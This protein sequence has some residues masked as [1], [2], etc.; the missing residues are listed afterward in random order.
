[1]VA[2]SKPDEFHTLIGRAMND[3]AF[4]AKLIDPDQ[5]AQALRQVGI[6]NP[7][8]EQLTA[9]GEA[10]EAIERVSTAFGIVKAAM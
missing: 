8:R 4:R 2:T 6:E 9:I 1:M 7:T 10:F 3:P 5:R